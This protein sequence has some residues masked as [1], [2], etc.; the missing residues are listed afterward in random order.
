MY[1]DPIISKYIE[2]IKANNG[3]IKT[4]Y[5][6]EPIRIAASLLPCCIISKTGTNVGPITNAEDAHE[7]GLRITIITDV[8]S[9]LSS[10]ES[11]T[12]IVK[13]V[14]TL[15]DLMEGRNADYSLKDTSILDILR[16]NID[17]DVANNLRTD[18]GS[19]TRVD[20]GLTL[21]DRA[22]EQ[23]TIEARLDFTANFS[24]VR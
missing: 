7:L 24:Q 1:D 16:G 11:N 4:Y 17:V 14:A 18:L 8:R 2:L 20:Y 19:V 21:R 10:E 13:G 9:E 22:P 15:Y 3:E 12:A 5:Q 6:G 23:W